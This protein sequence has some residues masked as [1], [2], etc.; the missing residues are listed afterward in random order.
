M[1]NREQSPGGDA[2]RVTCLYVTPDHPKLPLT[3]LGYEF[4]TDGAGEILTS[5]S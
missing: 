1:S 2:G 5:R 4:Q 3:H